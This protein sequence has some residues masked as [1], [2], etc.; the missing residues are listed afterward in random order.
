MLMIWERNDVMAKS[1]QENPVARSSWSAGHC[2][3]VPFYTWFIDCLVSQMCTR[4][5]FD[6]HGFTIPSEPSSLTHGFRQSL[7]KRVWLRVSDSSSLDGPSAYS[8]C[9]KVRFRHVFISPYFPVQYNS[10]VLLKV[11]WP[12]PSLSSSPGTL[13]PIFFT[14]W[15]NCSFS[16]LFQPLGFGITSRL[17]TD[18]Q[19]CI[20]YYTLNVPGLLS[21]L[22]I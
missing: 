4:V 20:L 22:T 7:P 18:L 9:P 11:L 13:C 1:D 10:L 19:V 2:T 6:G 17:F 3:P 15:T 21:P 8:L 5:D 12:Y 14:I 16:D